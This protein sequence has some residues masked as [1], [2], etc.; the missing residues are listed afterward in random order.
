MNA[1]REERPWL[2][3]VWSFTEEK[4][5]NIGLDIYIFWYVWYQAKGEGKIWTKECGFTPA[6]H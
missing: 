3:N 4:A 2:I 6:T 1:Q 5:I